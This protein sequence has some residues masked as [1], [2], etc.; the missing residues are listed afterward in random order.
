MGSDDARFNLLLVD[1]YPENLVSLKAILDDPAYT[2]FTAASGEEA[3]RLALRET[4]AVV[5]LDVVMP[6]M[7]GFEVAKHLK[8]LERTRNIPIIFLTAVATDIRQVYRA[9]DVGALDYLLKPLDPDVVRKKVAVLVDLTRQRRE[10]ERQNGLL[11][12]AEHREFELRL[13]ELHVAND[14]RYRCL[15]DGI[16]RA[17]AWTMAQD[18]RLTFVSR[19]AP[20]VL[21][22]PL[23]QFLEPDFWL[24]HVFEEDRLQFA[25]L[26]DRARAARPETDLNLNHRMVAADGRVLWFHTGVRPRL[27]DSQELHGV[28]VDVS[29]IKRAEET[30]LRATE[31][32]DQLLAIVS[33]DLRNP[34]A[35]ILMNAS[36]IEQNGARTGQGGTW[37]QPVRAILRSA[38]H[39]SELIEDLLDVSRIEAGGLSVEPDAIAA[40]P[41]V[42]ELVESLKPVAES[43]GLNFE[44]VTDEG[45]VLRADRRRTHQILRN[46]LGNAIKFTPRGGRLSLQIHREGP[47]AHLSVTDSGPGIRES[48]QA[49]VWKRSWHGRGGETGAGLGL[50]I[51]RALVEAHSGRIWLESQPGEGTTFHFTLPLDGKPADRS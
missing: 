35:A 20:S 49:M 22:F 8:E 25:T 41:L 26:L 37:V 42:E 44:V 28:S 33:H 30:A 31:M 4:F 1:D 24:R 48:D 46:L 38:N 2:L 50:W 15:V 17:I 27:P 23:E 40:A 5:L 13:A 10:I 11:R 16:D 34:L 39:M 43:K 21:G 51:A 45:V 3:L 29:E 6:K 9:Y 7:D 19:Q 14:E 32:R 36:M 47:N 12:A 18:G